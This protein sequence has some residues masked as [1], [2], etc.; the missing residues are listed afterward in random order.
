M[1]RSTR[2]AIVCEASLCLPT[3]WSAQAAAELQGGGL[4]SSK[5]PP[6]FGIG[7]ADDISA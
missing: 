6:G 7:P 4:Q 3:W 2:L 1:T 5:A